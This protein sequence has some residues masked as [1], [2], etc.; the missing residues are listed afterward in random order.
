MDLSIAEQ[1]IYPHVDHR[2]SISTS[3]LLNLSSSRWILMEVDLD[4]WLH[5]ILRRGVTIADN[6]STGVRQHVLP[7][8]R[9][10]EYLWCAVLVDPV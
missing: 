5:L 4:V 3:R 7:A 1:A 6:L 10:L 8:I 9:S 2:S